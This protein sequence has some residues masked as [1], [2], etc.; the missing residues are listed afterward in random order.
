MD[1]T[2]TAPVVPALREDAKL[3]GLIS[4]AHGASHFSQLLLAPLFPWI[5]EEFQVSY[6]ELGLV[7]SIFFVVSCAV[8]TASGFVV[9][10]LGPRP[11]LF[12][13]LGLL[14]AAALGFASAPSYGWL[15]AWAVV[16]GV[17]NG[18][19]HPVDYSLLNRRIYKDRLGHAYSLH[20][21]AGSLGWA[22]APALLVP[23]AVAWSWRVALLGAA[24]VIAA[25]LLLQIWHRARLALEPA[26][27]Q[28]TNLRAVAGAASVEQP[29]AFLGIPAVWMCFLFFLVYAGALSVI[30]TYAPEAARH[31]H[32][33][34]IHLAAGCLSIYMVCSALGMLGGGFLAA[35][36]TRCVQI[37]G[38]GLGLAAA[39]ALALA[40]LPVP[41]AV[42]PLF[43]AAMGLTTGLASPSRDM[44][45]KQCTPPNATGRVY[46]VVYSG[47]DIGQA[48][49]PLFFGYLMDLHQYQA[50]WLGLAALQLLMVGTAVQVRRVRRVA[51]ATA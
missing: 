47:L 16:A 49:S 35:D 39:F 3:I 28:A 44:L 42:V 30:Q 34:P 5:R 14:L 37:V 4:L 50:V 24:V 51:L 25:V 20:G 23:L 17:G 13:G 21:V 12:A 7:L 27:R 46:G 9:D 26:D 19:F 48:L 31:L 6:A 10:R 11:V 22:L 8:Q 40:L 33:V 41:A 38:I 1:S 43:F 32:Q 18:V 36:P 45:V 29:F 2:L 15:A